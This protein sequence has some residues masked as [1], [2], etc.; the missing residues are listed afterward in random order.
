MQKQT[1]KYVQTKAR[2]K[3]GKDQDRVDRWSIL[4]QVAPIFWVFTMLAE[5][6]FFLPRRLFPGFH[7]G[8]FSFSH[9]FVFFIFFNFFVLFDFLIFFC[10]SSKC[11]LL[12]FHQDAHFFKTFSYFYNFSRHFTID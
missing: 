3:A 11:H 12:G 4:K 7:Q 8:T 1:G 5:I 9:F 10:E 2:L 6:L